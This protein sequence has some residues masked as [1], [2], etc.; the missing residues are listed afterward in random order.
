MTDE[1]GPIQ[2]L[3]LFADGSC[4]LQIRKH[5]GRGYKWM[6][7]VTTDI[8]SAAKRFIEVDPRYVKPSV[9]NRKPW[10][11]RLFGGKS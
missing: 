9:E 5:A 8:A 10:W 1:T 6:S 4:R 11:R 7:L 3:E 2:I